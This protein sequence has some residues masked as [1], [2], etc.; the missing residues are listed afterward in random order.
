MQSVEKNPMFK[1]KI[2]QS[3]I[4]YDIILIKTQQGAKP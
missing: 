4:Y 1:K 3:N 2:T